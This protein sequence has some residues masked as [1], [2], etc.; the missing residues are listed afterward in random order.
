M[1]DAS[2]WEGGRA[3]MESIDRSELGPLAIPQAIWST[4]Q[5]T[6]RGYECLLGLYF[7]F[8]RLDSELSAAALN[9]F[10]GA[11]TALVAYRLARLV[12]SED[13]A[14]RTGWLVCFFPSMIIW[15]IQTIKE[16]IVILCEICS[17]YACV[18]LRS[19]GFSSRHILLWIVSFVLVLSLRFYVAYALG[20]VVVLS[21]LIPNLVRKSV[22][23]GSALL[24]GIVLFSFL[25]IASSVV[26]T[27]QETFESYD[28]D[29]VQGFREAVTTGEGSGSGVKSSYDLKSS[30]GLVLGT[31]VGALHLMLAPFPWQF[32]GSS[33]RF[34]LTAPEM[35]V[36]WVLVARGLFPGLTRCIRR[37]PGDV[38]SMLFFMILLASIYSLMFGNIG[39]IYRQRAQLMPYLFMIIMVG[40]EASRAR[41]LQVSQS[42]AHFDSI[43]PLARTSSALELVS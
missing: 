29:R 27:H 39:I 36:W 31:L 10:A 35:I 8:S 32:A 38:L 9:C 34:L 3:F 43:M 41:R 40:F 12:F 14:Q 7:Y 28:L 23:L 24:M 21:L 18:A 13:V 6:N 19:R 26:Q 20:A 42:E 30:Q 4:Y 22:L 37:Q 1:A 16:P 2:G 15:S 11:V 33:T 5:R 25:S 17:M